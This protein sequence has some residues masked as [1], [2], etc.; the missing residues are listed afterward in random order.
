MDNLQLQAAATYWQDQDHKT[1]SVPQRPGRRTNCTYTRGK[2]AIH[3][4]GKETRK[5]E[6]VTFR[7]T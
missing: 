7:H 2:D 1:S 3:T 6:A 5:D 4:E